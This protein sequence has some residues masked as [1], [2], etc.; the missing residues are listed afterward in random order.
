MNPENQGPSSKS[1]ASRE[2]VSPPTKGSY[3]EYDPKEIEPRWRRF[4]DKAH[5][6]FFRGK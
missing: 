6:I 5:L 2:C 1:H 3:S 4:W